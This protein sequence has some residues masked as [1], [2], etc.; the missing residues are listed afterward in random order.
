MTCNASQPRRG[1]SL[2]AAQ[3][4][5]IGYV[6]GFAV[7]VATAIAAL[8]AGTSDGSSSSDA[9]SAALAGYLFLLA[10]A[11]IAAVVSMRAARRRLGLHGVDLGLRATPV[12]RR[13][14]GA[15]AVMYVGLLAAAIEVTITALDWCGVSG[16]GVDAGVTR[17]PGA[18]PVETVHSAIAGLVEEP[19]LLALPIALGRRCRWPWQVTLTVM[20]A[21]RISFHLYLG[22]DCLF[23]VPWIIGAFVLYRW[24]SLLWPFVIGHGLFDLLQTWQT[25]GGHA[26]ALTAEALLIAAT[27]AA[28]GIAGVLVCR[29]AGLFV[30][31]GSVTAAGP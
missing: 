14:A 26:A 20:I 28:A 10:L 31:P 25:Y 4:L 2:R 22:W 27:L 5:L 9:P 12:T 24:C 23:V 29:R 11:L 1:S 13:R 15:A 3:I 7:S 30:S 19:V 18:L 21:M 8:T 16:S 6:L 17:S